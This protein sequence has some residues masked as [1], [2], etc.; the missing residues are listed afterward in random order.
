MEK[1][2]QFMLNISIPDDIDNQ[3]SSIT[4]NKQEFILAAIRQKIA[5]RKKTS[6]PEELAKEY[7]ESMEENKLLMEDFKHSDAENWDDY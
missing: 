6:S 5:I 1:L 4:N 2:K 3:L 7:K